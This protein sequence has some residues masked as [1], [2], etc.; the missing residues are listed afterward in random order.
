MAK[1]IKH[2]YLF[3]TTYL[4]EENSEFEELEDVTVKVYEYTDKAEAEQL[5]LSERKDYL[6]INIQRIV[7]TDDSFTTPEDIADS[8][9]QELVEAIAPITY[10]DHEEFI[11]HA[12]KIDAHAFLSKFLYIQKVEI[13]GEF[14][15]ESLVAALS[16]ALKKINK[17]SAPEDW[18][19]I[20][21]HDRSIF[22]NEKPVEKDL[23]TKIF[24]DLGFFPLPQVVSDVDKKDNVLSIVGGETLN[25]D[26]KFSPDMLEEKKKD[27]K[28]KH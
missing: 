4:V 19:A 11:A 14:A 9:S 20:A 21:Y 28:M 12:L 6:Q 13:H 3:D 18:V 25:K 24:K 23:S 5:E 17:G 8:D 7:M 16:T 27:K 22:K 2:P 26:L 10:S 1:K 15:E